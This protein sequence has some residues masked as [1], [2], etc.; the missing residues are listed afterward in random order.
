MLLLENIYVS[1][2]CI[3]V[4]HGISLKVDEGEIVAIIGANGAGKSTTLKAISGLVKTREDSRIEF[5]GKRIG[6]IGPSNVVKAGISL[7]PEGRRIFPDLTVQENLEMG[8]FL[9]IREKETVRQDMQRMFQIFPRL[10]ERRRQIGKTLSGGEL[11]MLAIARALMTRPQLLMLDEPSTGLAPLIVKDIF[12]ILK[13]INGEG[14]SVL[15]VEQNAKM[16]LAIADRAYV[17]K[18]GVIVMEGT[19]EE[20]LKND[21]VRKAYLGEK[22]YKGKAASERA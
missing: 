10:E 3:E 19:G 15:M 2:D 8:A 1:Y 21:E 20:L 16:T 4:L 18:N 13:Q 7:V 9:H 12:Q 17:L 11:Q 22:K 6:N 14:T 5:K